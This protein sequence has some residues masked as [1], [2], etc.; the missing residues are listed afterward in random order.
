[1]TSLRKD[2]IN[3]DEIQ[4]KYNIIKQLGNEGIDGYVVLVECKKTHNK[5]AMKIFK[6]KK[7][8]KKIKKEIKL[9]QKASSHNIAPKVIDFSD[10]WFVME[11]MYERLFD[12]LAKQNNTLTN[13]QID[14]IIYLYKSLSKINILHNDSNITY[15]ILLDSNGVFK[16][17]DFGLSKNISKDILIKKGPFPNYSLLSNLYKITNNKYLRTII[18]DYEKKYNVIIDIYEHQRRLVILL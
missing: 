8:I 18:D 2:I 16:L 14:Q 10:Y 15:N 12:V 7:S 17:I 6:N 9:L 11:L 5:Y 1:M 13:Y 4:S 3:S